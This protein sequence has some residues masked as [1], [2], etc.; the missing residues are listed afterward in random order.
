[1]AMDEGGRH[2]FAIH[3]K[4][5]GI[6][7]AIIL[8]TEDRV[9][10]L[11]LHTDPAAAEAV[12]T[13]AFAARLHLAGDSLSGY[14]YRLSDGAA[15]RHSLA[16]TGSLDGVVVGEPQ[17]LVDVRASHQWARDCGLSGPDLDSLM[18]ACYRV[19]GRIHAETAVGERPVSLAAVAVAL[20]QDLHG[21]LADCSLV[22]VGSGEAGAGIADALVQAGAVRSDAVNG[23]LDDLVKADILVAATGPQQRRID[24]TSIHEALR[25]RRQKPIFLIDAAIPGDID[26]E[27]NRLDGAYL[28]DLNDL[29]RIAMEGRT[30]REGAARRAWAIV[31][32]E[33]DSYGK[34]ALKTGL[35]PFLAMTQAGG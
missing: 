34:G 3:L 19:A 15:V 2:D 11:A 14:L 13:T 27:A 33:V 4:A 9:E 21:D 10:V 35:L 28:Y 24:A 23:T 22:V 17:I 26:T 1:M 8:S 18:A 20:A 30:A 16:V 31:D 7:Q 5:A 25:K 6:A 32:A 12:I 29:E